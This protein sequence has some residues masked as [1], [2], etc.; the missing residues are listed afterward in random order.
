MFQRIKEIP[1]SKR[2]FP[3][4]LPI[5]G[6]ENYSKI[7]ERYR[8]LFE[9]HG[10]PTHPEL[11]RHIIQGILPG[12]AFYQ[13]L[14]ERGET[15]ESALEIIDQAF[16]VLFSDNITRMNKLGRLSLFYP[17]L[18]IF[19]KPAMRQYPPEGWSIEWV[20]ND[21]TAIRFNMKSCFYFDVFSRY[22]VPELTRSF[23]RVD[24]LTFG[25]MSP[26]IKWERFKTIARGGSY[27]DFCFLSI[28]K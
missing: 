2:F 3:R 14:R 22:G 25:T 11:Q 24:D 21:K 10:L 28:K 9:A 15:Q 20:Q 17:F 6:D 8:S 1:I 26:Y 13:I 27:C 5:L 23:C 19:I 4:L 18:R 16:E 7:R 12:L